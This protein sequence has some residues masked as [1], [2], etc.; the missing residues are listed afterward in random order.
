M[1][2]AIGERGFVVRDEKQNHRFVYETD[3]GTAE[4]VYG[5]R[6]GRLV[7]IHTGVPEAMG[8]RGIGGQLVTAAVERAR[9]EGLTL[10]PHC[11]YARRWLE[12]HREAADG[13]T[14]DFDG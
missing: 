10:V 13:V 14:I 7:L 5:E 4:L 11:P 2:D 1:M 6:P 12:T 8:G 9:A 3:E